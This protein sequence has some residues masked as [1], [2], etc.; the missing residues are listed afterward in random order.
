[1]AKTV[2]LI[3]PTI[4]PEGVAFLKAKHQVTVAPDG[5]EATL[6][7]CIQENRASAV[8]PRVEHITRKIIEACPSLE[9]IGQPGGLWQQKIAIFLI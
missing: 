9:E 5:S 6:I 3:A 4:I 7:R 1:M 8:I 2:V